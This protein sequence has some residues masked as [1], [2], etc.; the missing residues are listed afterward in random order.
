VNKTHIPA[1]DGLRAVAVGL[2]FLCHAR[3][4]GFHEGGLGVDVFFVLSGYLIT[5]LLTREIDQTGTLDLVRFYLRRLKRLTPPLL[6]LAMAYL[7]LAPAVWRE[8]TVGEHAGYVIAAVTYLTDFARSGHASFTNPLE[9]TWSL[10]VEEHFYMLWPLLLLGF[11][12]LPKRLLFP[13][14]LTGFALATMW[15]WTGLYLYG[16]D[17][18]YFRFDFRLSGLLLGA[19]LSVFASAG[20]T[21]P[22][23]SRFALY[24]G[25]L[26]AIVVSLAGM[27]MALALCTFA[28]AAAALTI[29]AV[30]QGES[31][32]AWLA[33][34]VPVY[35]GRVSYGFYLFHFPL[36]WW[37][38]D[39]V[40]W[41]IALLL[42][43]SGGLLLA[44]LSYHFVERPVLDGGFR[45][46]TATATV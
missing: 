17:S 19:V 44:S 6:I 21:I 11:S 25:V 37:L 14:L 28:E 36:T 30:L 1:L 39:H 41:P 29:L 26:S 33:H 15:R 45:T 43:G 27:E 23:L 18:A 4:P 34:P 12:Y 9:H 35:V 38:T 31:W 10:A 40:S 7:A 2:V 42:G 22:G 16:W 46:R 8:R 13:A 32:T 5:G 3:V 20:K 24:A